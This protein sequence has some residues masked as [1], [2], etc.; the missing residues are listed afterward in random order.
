MG[1]DKFEPVGV[2]SFSIFIY[3]NFTHITGA[4]GSGEV[5]NLVIDTSSRSFVT[6][7]GV[8]GIGKVDA[9]T[10]FRKIDHVAFWRE[11]EDTIFKDINL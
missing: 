1:F 3:D 5:H 8:N 10:F 4:Q 7:V 2:W 11:N 6:D 9:C